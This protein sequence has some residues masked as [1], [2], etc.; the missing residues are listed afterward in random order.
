MVTTSVKQ[1]NRYFFLPAFSFFSLLLLLLKWTLAGRWRHIPRSA[2][3][4]PLV[5]RR[6]RDE[7][8]AAIEASA[9][10][11][12]NIATMSTRGDRGF[13][14]EKRA[15]STCPSA[16]ERKERADRSISARRRSLPCHC[17]RYCEFFF[18]GSEK[19]ARQRISSCAKKLNSASSSA[20]RSAII[21]VSPRADVHE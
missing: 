3:H 15:A 20:I 12:Q 1:Y 11:N 9:K 19:R 4:V 8:A 2:S 5:T 18:Q 6:S 14:K 10:K 7:R 17:A 16:R 13:R 21:R